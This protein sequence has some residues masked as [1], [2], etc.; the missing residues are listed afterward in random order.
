VKSCKLGIAT[1]MNLS[2]EFARERMGGRKCEGELLFCCSAAGD[3]HGQ[4]TDARVLRARFLGDG[5]RVVVQSFIVGV[6]D[7]LAVAVPAEV[8]EALPLGGLLWRQGQCVVIAVMPLH[9]FC[10]L[11]GIELF[12]MPVPRPN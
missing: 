9:G 4:A 7:V 12:G 5:A 6:Q 10:G 1:R 2:P 11:R 3:K 8:L